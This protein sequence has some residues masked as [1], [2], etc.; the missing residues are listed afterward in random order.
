M[1]K[2]PRGTIGAYKPTGYMDRV[3]LFHISD[4]L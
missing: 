4:L 2:M 3:D 1:L